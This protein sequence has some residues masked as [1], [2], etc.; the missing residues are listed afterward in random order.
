MTLN[1]NRSKMADQ[2]HIGRKRDNSIQPLYNGQRDC[3]GRDM[4]DTC[5]GRKLG[6]ELCREDLLFLLSML[7]GELQVG[8]IMNNT[9]PHLFPSF[10]LFEE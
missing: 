4:K 6:K 1:R 3:S 5:K 7:E 2:N 8:V 9:F 10:M